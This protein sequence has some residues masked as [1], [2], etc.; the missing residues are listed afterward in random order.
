MQVAECSK[1]DIYLTYLLLHLRHR[2]H[3]LEKYNNKQ[4]CDDICLTVLRLIKFVTFIFRR[5][6]LTLVRL[7]T[8]SLRLWETQA[9]DN[10][11]NNN[12]NNDDDD[13]DGDDDDNNN[14]NNVILE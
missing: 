6:D 13:D 3:S 10:N 9:K 12:N 11:N 7:Y 4:T 14:D 8:P 2:R 1:I 5:P